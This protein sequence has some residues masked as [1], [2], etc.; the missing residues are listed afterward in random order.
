[1]W[2]LLLLILLGLVRLPLHIR[3]LGLLLFHLWHSVLQ[4]AS[5]WVRTQLLGKLQRILL[6]WFQV[7]LWPIWPWAS[8]A[9]VP[10]QAHAEAV[11]EARAGE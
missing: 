4:G 8:Q 3:L 5:A 2:L 11:K 10:L 6:F 9:L 7:S 1:M